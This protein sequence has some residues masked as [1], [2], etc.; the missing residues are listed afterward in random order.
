MLC[1]VCFIADVL[2]H[3]QCVDA[4]L[5]AAVQQLRVWAPRLTVVVAA[6]AMCVT[7]VVTCFAPSLP[8]SQRRGP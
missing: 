6:A 5:L 1:Q 2:G 3:D 7:V 8:L 4:A